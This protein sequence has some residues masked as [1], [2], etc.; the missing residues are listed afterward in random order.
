[1]LREISLKKENLA[2]QTMLL[3]QTKAQFDA[4]DSVDFRFETLPTSTRLIGSKK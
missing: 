1:M 2:R 4:P 3:P